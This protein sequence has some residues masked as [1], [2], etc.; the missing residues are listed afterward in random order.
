M[1]RRNSRFHWK[2]CTPPPSIPGRHRRC[3]ILMRRATNSPPRSFRCETARVGRKWRAGRTLVRATRAAR[4]RGKIE[5]TRDAKTLCH[6]LIGSTTPRTLMLSLWDPPSIEYENVSAASDEQ[7]LNTSPTPTDR[8][9]PLPQASTPVVMEAT[10]KTERRRKRIFSLIV[11]ESSE[12]VT[13]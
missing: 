10:R 11:G 4:S 13:Y 6:Q 2:T 1:T 3:N 7:H 9:S 12:Q 8:L 5:K